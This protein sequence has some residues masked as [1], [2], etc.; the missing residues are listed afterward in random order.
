MWM[1][2][3]L[4]K[5]CHGGGTPVH[6]LVTEALKE[7][8]ETDVDSGEWTLY[9]YIDPDALDSLFTHEGN[10]I[11]SVEFTVRGATVTVW[12]DDDVQVKVE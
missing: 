11:P 7:H 1:T 6:E 10:T 5:R 3:K 12:Q 4:G 9:D 2:R 8:D